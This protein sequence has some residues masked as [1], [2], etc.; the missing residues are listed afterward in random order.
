MQTL[1]M[2]GINSGANA[3]IALINDDAVNLSIV[4]SARSLNEN[5]KIISRVNNSNSKKKFEIAGVNET[6]LFNDVTAFVASEYLGQPAAF[7]AID[8]IL[9]NKDVKA[10][11]DEVEVLNESRIIGKNINLINFKNYNL[12]LLGIINL[13][14]F[15]EFIFNPTNFDYIVQQNDILIIIGV[16]NSVSQLK[17]DLIHLDFKA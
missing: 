16:K 5:I 14:N 4:L 6:I 17:A 8:G 10:I 9:L 1:E 12:T 2:I 7:E 13:Y 15:D 11:I 3:I